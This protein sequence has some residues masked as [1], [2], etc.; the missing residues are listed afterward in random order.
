MK[1]RRIALIGAGAV[2]AYL[3]WSFERTANITLTV[4][5]EGARAER[6]KRDGI[7][8]NGYI[9]RSVCRNPARRAP[10]I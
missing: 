10:R 5:A 2:G 4:V 6:L 3:I 7:I 1:I 8:I 9:I